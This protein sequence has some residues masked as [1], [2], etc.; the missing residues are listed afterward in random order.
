MGYNNSR[1]AIKWWDPH[2]NTLKTISSAEF[3]EDNN[4]FRKGWSPD[5]ELMVGINVPNLPKFEIYISD[6]PFIRDGIFEVTVIFNQEVLPLVL[7]L[8]TVS[9][10][11]CP[12][13]PSQQTIYLVA[14]LSL[15]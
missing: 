14:V 12:I 11:T 6:H 8:N 13:S 15:V 10:I 4:K 7:L 2:T 9:I 5:S 1:A 3:D